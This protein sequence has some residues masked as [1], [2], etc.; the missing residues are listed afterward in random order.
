M[1]SH[2]QY[3][4]SFYRMTTNYL[5]Y[6]I[7]EFID[8]RQHNTFRFSIELYIYS[9]NTIIMFIDFTILSTFCHPIELTI[10]IIQ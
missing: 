3:I 7:S 9:F 8:L 2:I 5:F 4:S 6:T 1:M 10:R